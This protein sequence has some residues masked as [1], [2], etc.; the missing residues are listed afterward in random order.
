M[1][2]DC[3]ILKLENIT[4]LNSIVRGHLEVDEGNNCVSDTNHI[5][6]LY[7]ANTETTV[8]HFVRGMSPVMALSGIATFCCS[9]WLVFLNALLL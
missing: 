3:T 8:K 1:I 4:Q 7:V 5:L 9:N 6:I 2:F